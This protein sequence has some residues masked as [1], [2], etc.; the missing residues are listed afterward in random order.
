MRVAVIGVMGNAGN[1]SYSMRI[2]E[3]LNHTHT[4]YCFPTQNYEPWTADGINRVYPISVILAEHVDKIEYIIVVQSQV[5]IHNDT[6]IPLLLFK[7][8][9]VI[10]EGT[11]D[12]PTI[13]IKKLETLEDYNKYEHV[14]ASAIAAYKYDC[15]QEKDI[16]LL[17]VPWLPLPFEE[18]INRVSRAQHQLI[19]QRYHDIDTYTCR[20]IESMACKTI[21]IIL[22]RDHT[23]K[24]M[25]ENIGID[26]SVAYFVSIEK[27]GDLQIK[28][29]NIEMAEKGHKLVMDKFNMNYHANTFMELLLENA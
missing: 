1:H 5:W 22:Y 23:T 24:Q 9:N 19:M 21:P 11:V 4:A 3:V 29:Y 17:D 26:D 14:I 13:I 2:A 7:T 28:E 15:T 10:P 25:Y 16:I 12:N 20:V 8:E 27:Y 18:Y 6:D